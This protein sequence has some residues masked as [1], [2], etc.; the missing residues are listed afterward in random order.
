MGHYAAIT[1][2]YC[3][4]RVSN[5][6]NESYL[7]NY[8]KASKVSSKGWR[9]DTRMLTVAGTPPPL[10]LLFSI[11]Q[12]LKNMHTLLIK[13]ETHPLFFER[14][15]TEGSRGFSRFRVHPGNPTP[16]SP[17]C[18]EMPP[19]LRQVRQR[20]GTRWPWH[21]PPQTTGRSAREWQAGALWFQT[22][23][24]AS[25]REW[26]RLR[27]WTAPLSGGP[28]CPGALRRLFLHL[29][30]SQ[31]GRSREFPRQ[32]DRQ[33]ATSDSSRHRAQMFARG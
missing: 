6:R 20:P 25:R 2:I 5:N 3:L 11:F 33:T 18:P 19:G 1:N 13:W 14:T 29:R 21:S 24:G 8:L 23:K 9:E 27:G 10:I 7:S 30:N 12:L 22:A 15:R 31:K 32:A 4:Q 16:A 26:P 28:A 17:H